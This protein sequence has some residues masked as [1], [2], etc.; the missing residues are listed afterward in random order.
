L[1]DLAIAKCE[2]GAGS[3]ICHHTE[4]FFNT[5]GRNFLDTPWQDLFYKKFNNDKFIDFCHNY[6]SLAQRPIDSVLEA[7]WFFYAMCKTRFQLLNK[8]DLFAHY[9]NFIP[10]RLQG[11]YDC[12]QFENYIYWNIDQ[13]IPG[14]KYSDWK[15]PFKKYC[16]DFDNFGDYYQTKQKVNSRQPQQYANKQQ[17]LQDCRSIFYLNN[18]KR[19]ATSN[20]PFFSRKEFEEQYGNT[21]NYLFNDPD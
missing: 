7:R 5:Y 2:S 19:I 12:E 17:I 6:F 11:F 8:I 21:L 15:L 16:F 10:S 3:I 14:H 1:E 13:T 20:L 4:S 18:G 9:D